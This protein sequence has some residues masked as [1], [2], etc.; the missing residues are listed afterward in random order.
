MARR[1]P[2]DGWVRRRAWAASP[3][4]RPRHRHGDGL[5]SHRTISR[6][7]G[8]GFRR[9]WARRLR[10]PPW[11]RRGWHARAAHALPRAL[12]RVSAHLGHPHRARRPV[13]EV[14]RRRVSTTGAAQVLRLHQFL[15]RRNCSGHPAPFRRLRGHAAHAARPPHHDELRKGPAMLGRAA[16]AI[17]AG[18]PPVG[19]AGAPAGDDA[20]GHPGGHWSQG[21]D[22]APDRRGAGLGG[23]RGRGRRAGG[24][25]GR[26]GRG[27]RPG[28]CAPGGGDGRDAGR[29]LVSRRGVRGA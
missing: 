28:R 2:E 24:G 23:R 11:Q 6:A 29:L 19:A 14:Q 9:G 4:R 13:R 10:D 7:G 25:W 18:G 17:P 16:G 26:L 22:G 27:W 15:L 8:R 21:R 1:R 3:V 12:L 20:R 5:P